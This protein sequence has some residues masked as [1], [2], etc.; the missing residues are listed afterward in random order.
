M[1]IEEGLTELTAISRVLH[2]RASATLD[3][4][5]VHDIVCCVVMS[6]VTVEWNES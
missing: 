1:P 4:T 3:S 5:W 6:K 2:T